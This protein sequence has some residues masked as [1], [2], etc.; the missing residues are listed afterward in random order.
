MLIA[1]SD[2]SMRRVPVRRIAKIVELRRTWSW[3]LNT[4]SEPGIQGCQT[5]DFI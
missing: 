5:L 2:L 4:W 3:L 1:S